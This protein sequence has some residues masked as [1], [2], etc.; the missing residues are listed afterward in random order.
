MKKMW[1][2]AVA[3]LLF[4][5]GCANHLEDVTKETPENSRSV[6]GTQYVLTMDK[7]IPDSS[8]FKVTVEQEVINFLIPA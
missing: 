5:A 2:S 3:G 6:L 4:A 8:S 1:M 7:D